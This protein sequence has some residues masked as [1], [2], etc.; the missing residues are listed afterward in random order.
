MNWLKGR[1]K[2][3]F[4]GL[5]YAFTQDRS[6]RLQG[7][8]GLIV[9]V[10]GFVFHCAVFL[11]GFS[12]NPEKVFPADTR[13]YYWRIT[14]LLPAPAICPCDSGKQPHYLPSI[15]HGYARLQ[16]PYPYLENH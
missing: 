2:Y 11:Q 9:I 14:C 8:F 1:F 3:A 15:W 5:Y 13:S 10:F 6:I 4:E 7:I 16:R 12:R